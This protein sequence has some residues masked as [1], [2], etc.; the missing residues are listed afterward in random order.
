MRGAD[1]PAPSE[2]DGDALLLTVIAR[3]MRDP[4]YARRR[5]ARRA[6]VRRQAVARRVLRAPEP[7]A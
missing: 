6:K 5:E 4:E 2:P 1:D 3:C 7:P